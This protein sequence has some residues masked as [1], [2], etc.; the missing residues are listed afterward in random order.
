[1]GRAEGDNH[2]YSP[3]GHLFDA[4]EDIVGLLDQK[5]MLLACVK[6]FIHHNS[7]SPLGR[8]ALSEFFSQSVHIPGTALTQAQHLA[9]GLV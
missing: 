6:L 5:C 3:V 9:L 8:A 4:A 2:L 7:Q 1:M